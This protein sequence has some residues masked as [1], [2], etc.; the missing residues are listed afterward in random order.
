[1]ETGWRTTEKDSEWDGIMAYMTNKMSSVAHLQVPN[2]VICP[3]PA[4]PPVTFTLVSGGTTWDMEKDQWN[5]SSRDSSMLACGRME[6]RYESTTCTRMI[7]MI[8]LALSINTLLRQH[9]QGTHIWLPQKAD[10]SQYSIINRYT[11]E[12]NQGQKHGLGTFYYASGVTYEGEWSNDRRHAKV[13]Q[14]AAYTP[15]PKHRLMPKEEK[16]LRTPC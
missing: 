8:I 14:S 7:I 6:F 4:T 5:G 9:G 13:N 12:F 10:G 11:G 2:R 1:M 3:S 16:R 15:T